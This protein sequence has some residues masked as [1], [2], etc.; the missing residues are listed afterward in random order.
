MPVPVPRRASPISR[1]Q[2]IKRSQPPAVLQNMT[3]LTNYIQNPRTNG[4]TNGKPVNGDSLH[5]RKGSKHARSRSSSTLLPSNGHS[6]PIPTTQP[7]PLPL[8]NLKDLPLAVKKKIDWEIP[9]KTLHSSI[10]ACV[11]PTYGVLFS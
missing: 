10:G 8:D 11:A 3:D 2:E 6:A 4:Y 7:Q 9:R 1:I 5:R